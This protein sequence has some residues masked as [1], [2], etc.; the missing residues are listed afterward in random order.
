M[1]L[2]W[3]LHQSAYKASEVFKKIAKKQSMTERLL[4]TVRS[5]KTT[6]SYD[7]ATG[8]PEIGFDPGEIQQPEVTLDEILGYLEFLMRGTE[9]PLREEID[10]SDRHPQMN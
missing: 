3:H 6:I 10:K 8:F 7:A 1:T 5:L 2:S 4:R 9:R